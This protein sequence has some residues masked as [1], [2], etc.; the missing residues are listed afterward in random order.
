MM[1]RIF[2]LPAFALLAAGCGGS[3]P[4][5]T[6][7]TPPETT[8]STAATATSAA[9]TTTTT[10]AATTT[11]PTTTSTTTSTIPE[12]A[13]P[14]LYA[15]NCAQCHGVQLEGGVGPALG[16]GG[17]AQGHSDAELVELVTNGRNTMPAFG[18]KLSPEQIVALI[19]FIREA[20]TGA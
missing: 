15:A 4:V 20:D 3:E 14:D 19:A 6:E 1:K 12:P 18:E 16:S 9:L 10:I 5:A 17:H 8:T 11:A 13:A 2:L 7:P